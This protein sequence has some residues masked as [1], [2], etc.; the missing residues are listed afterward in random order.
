MVDPHTAADLV[1]GVGLLS[2][3]SFPTNLFTLKNAPLAFLIQFAYGIDSQDHISATPGWMESQEYDISAKVE[4]DRQ[5][6]LNQMR[7]MLP[8]EN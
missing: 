1:R 2:M 3:S 7:P 6:T 5:L 8:T 4:G